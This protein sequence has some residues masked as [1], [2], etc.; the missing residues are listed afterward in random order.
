M[1]T[2]SSPTPCMNADSS[3]RTRPSCWSRVLPIDRSTRQ[4][5]HFHAPYSVYQ[6]HLRFAS[7]LTPPPEMNAIQT[8][9]HLD[10]FREG[11]GH[12]FND[13]VCDPTLHNST[14]VPPVALSQIDQHPV[15]SSTTQRQPSPTGAIV[16]ASTVVSSLGHH[17]QGVTHVPAAS[18]SSPT[19]MSTASLDDGLHELA[20]QVSRHLFL[21]E[22]SV[23]IL[24][25]SRSHACFGLS[26]LMSWKPSKPPQMATFFSGRSHPMPGLH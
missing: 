17:L 10:H 14:S 13:H 16:R 25:A 4:V 22:H 3:T 21:R 24:T 11:H 8:Y 1:T 5:D 19:P 15:A 26:R 12:R 18:S 7:P 23:V 2:T 20:A 9:P 6:P